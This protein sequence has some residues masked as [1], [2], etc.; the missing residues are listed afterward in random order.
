M[1]CVPVHDETQPR[2]HEKSHL[3][4]APVNAHGGPVPSR[5]GAVP[6]MR[7]FGPWRR[8]RRQ[9]AVARQL[10]GEVV[11][12]ARQ[13]VFYGALGVPDTA[14][15]RFD[16][17]ALHAFLMLRRL[18]RDHGETRHLA[19]ELFDLMFVDMD[20]NLREMGIGDL[21]VG[22][23]VKG[24]AKAFYGRIAAYESG[25]DDGDAVLAEALRRNLFRKIEPAEG[26]VAAMAA[27]VRR[28]A[29][30]LDAVA[31]DRLMAGNVRF[32]AAPGNPSHED[33]GR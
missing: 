24:M 19:Q 33:A 31:V 5:G 32:V 16:L 25:L 7:L 8:S 1:P 18:R 29:T 13:P 12:Q 15:G 28:A 10:Y 21:S 11:R 27:Y 3:R 26:Q 17:I 6:A 30:A 4:A 20:E 23:R 14:D 22:K 9:A 2:G